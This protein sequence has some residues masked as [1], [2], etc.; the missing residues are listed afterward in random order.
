MRVGYCKLYNPGD[1]QS[2]NAAPEPQPFEYEGKTYWPGENSH[3]KANYPEGMKRLASAGR[4]HVAA[5]SIRYR[6][7]NGDFPYQERGNIWTDTITG[8]FT[9]EKIY[10]VQTN[11][12]VIERCILPSSDP[13]DL[14]FDSTCGSG[15]TAAAA[16]K[17]GRRWITCDT[18]RVAIALAHPR[19]P[20]AESV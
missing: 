3:W 2:Q 9:D 8:N 14:V 16:E 17:N 12:K 15:T 11:L 13:G 5:N 6:R 1:L 19:R 10:A 20:A 7:F 18:S 4:I